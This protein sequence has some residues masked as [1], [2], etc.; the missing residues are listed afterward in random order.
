[1]RNPV[2]SLAT[3]I[4]PAMAMLALAVPAG[5]DEGPIPIAGTFDLSG[6][7]ADVGRDVLDGVEV[8]IAELNSEGGV[9]GRQLELTYQD[10]GTNPQ[11]AVDQANLLLKDGAKFLLAP[12]S[13]ASAIAVSKTV[14]ASLK[15]PTCTSSSNSDD[16]TIKEFQPYVF[17]LSPN[18]Y[19]EM[20]AVASLLSKQPFKR[21]AVISADYAGGR[22]NANR[23]K[24]FIV[25]MNPEAE[26]VVEEYPKFGSTDYT[27]SI[28]KVLAAEPDYVW[29][30]LFGGDLITFSKQAKSLGFF[31]LVDNHF[32]ALYDGN[33]LNALSGAA[34][35][36]T[37]GWQRAP[38]N[39]LAA[40]SPEGKAFVEKFKA[41]VGRYPS[42]WATLAYDCVMT[43][44]QAVETAGTID[45]DPVM[46]A[47]ES[48]E[49]TS[50]RGPLRFGTYD[51]QAEAPIYIGQVVV[52]EE[53]DQPLLD[54]SQI[55][56]G[57]EVRP[58]EET[59]RTLRG[60]N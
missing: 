57:S 9:L 19:M 42:D 22:A 34:A 40:Q 29:T 54:I 30:V 35:E 31:D 10:N 7:A 50:I 59:V 51:H 15:V 21:Y 28:N 13:S 8:A 55:V 4:L 20:R 58:S 23:F 12:Q 27:A 16:I 49:F 2:R 53:Y 17:A 56:P 41:E 60:G 11:K 39:L 6:A 44:A 45:A 1:M 14:S 37:D 24:E 52:D 26:I 48:Q 47:I 38:F 18:S 36:G 32:M 33:T 3:H 25:E 43:W 5:A 46:N